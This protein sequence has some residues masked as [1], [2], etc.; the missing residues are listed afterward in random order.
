MEHNVRIT[1]RSC[2]AQT[3]L[4]VLFA[5]VGCSTNV[6]REDAVTQA[7]STNLQRM[8]TLY[9]N[10]QSENNWM[11]PADEA[12]FKQFISSLNDTFLSR[13]GVNKGNIDPVFISERDGQPFMIRYK[14]MGNMMGSNEPVVFESVGVDGKKMVG[15]LSMEQ[16]EIDPVEADAMLAGKGTTQSTARN[17]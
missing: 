17:N 10:Y 13:L 7:N 5:V 8:L 6:D 2:G 16:R 15:F 14:V 12:K 9:L 3:L 1:I 4:L 11:G